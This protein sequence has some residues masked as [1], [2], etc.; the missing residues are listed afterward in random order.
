MTMRARAKGLAKVGALLLVCFASPRARA[1]GS[2][3][4][5]AVGMSTGMATT[6]VLGQRRDAVDVLS[7]DANGRARWR[8]VD[9][10]VALAADTGADRWSVG[11]QRRLLLDQSVQRTGAITVRTRSGLR[12]RGV[13][14][15]VV[16]SGVDVRHADLRSASGATRVA[17][18]LDFSR[19]ARGV[20]PDLEARFGLAQPEGTVL[21]AVYSA[22]DLDRALAAEE[23]SGVPDAGL[24]VDDVGHGTLVASI[25]AGNGRATGAGLPAARYVGVAPE[26][27]LVVVRVTPTDSERV[28][29]A[30]VAAGV[31]FVLDRAEAMGM[32]AAVNLSVGSHYGTHDGGSPLERALAAM[33]PDE[34]AGRVL[35][36]AAGNDGTRAVHARVNLLAGETGEAVLGLPAGA[37]IDDVATVQVAYEGAVDVSVRFP[38]GP[39]TPWVSAGQARAYGADAGVVSVANATDAEFVGSAQYSLGNLPV[40]GAIVLFAAPSERTRP[41]GEGPWT[42]RVRGHG[43]V[44]LYVADAGSAG[45]GASWTTAAVSYGTVVVPATSPSVIAVG[46]RTTRLQWTRADGRSVT[47][48]D[49]PSVQDGVSA[50][51]AL[52][53]NR[54]NEAKPDLVAPGEWVLGAMSAQAGALGARSVFGSRTGWPE[55]A[56]VGDD[57]V[58]GAARGTSLAA[59][60]VTGALA[61]LLEAH[62]GATRGELA[63]ALRASSVLGGASSDGAAGWGDLAVDRALELLDANVAGGGVVDSARSHVSVAREAV[64]FGE[65]VSVLVRVR[66]ASGRATSPPAAPELVASAGT[67]DRVRARGYG[68]FEARWRA[69]GAAGDADHVRVLVNARVGAVALTDAAGVRVVARVSSGD[70]RVRAGGGCGVSRRGQGARWAVVAVVLLAWCRARRR[71]DFAR[72][73]PEV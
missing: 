58:H 46:S 59:P 5:R 54:R 36:A 49:G 62:P 19:P 9:R 31:A 43:P 12:G 68:V 39:E 53:P 15:G 22:G 7:V 13:V 25:A 57:G 55:G 23:A 48:L 60:H 38:G 70:G 69:D 28:S 20:H 27:T 65:S 14:V 6:G 52:G 50:F 72:Q 40:H 17:W 61:L 10:S 4:A 29:D 21:G 67:M 44:D 3:L 66:D 11:A 42:V 41:R 56:L 37:S 8:C 33:V 34:A 45:R 63:A 1:G 64:A 47:V 73:G 51:S 26:A 18:L 32:P 24:P 2:E 30:V 71:G 16:D 35:V